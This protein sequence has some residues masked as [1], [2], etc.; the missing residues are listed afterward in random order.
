[1]SKGKGFIAI[2]VGI[3]LFSVVHAED[4][5]IPT[6][7][8]HGC[9]VLY[10]A[11]SSTGRV[12]IQLSDSRFF[13]SDDSGISWQ[14]L[15]CP[16]TQIDYISDLGTNRFH[17]VSGSKIYRSDENAANWQIFSSNI[18]YSSMRSIYYDKHAGFYYI[19]TNGGGIFRSHDEGINWQQIGQ[20]FKDDQADIISVAVNTLGYIYVS[21][22]KTYPSTY[23]CSISRSTDN[24]TSW[25]NIMETHPSNKIPLLLAPNDSIF[26]MSQDNGWV[27]SDDNGNSWNIISM[28]TYSQLYGILTDN[29][30]IGTNSDHPLM[31]SFNAGNNWSDI[32]IS[33][34]PSK[35]G[36]TFYFDPFLAASGYD[37]INGYYFIG[38][39][40]GIFR[41]ADNGASWISLN[42]NI[43]LTEIYQFASDINGYLYSSTNSGIFRTTN[44][45]NAWEQFG[46]WMPSLPTGIFIKGIENVFFA[47]TRNYTL[48]RSDDGAENWNKL[49]DS[50]SII[51]ICTDNAGVLYGLKYY[52]NPYYSIKYI[53]ST[54]RGMT[55]SEKA[56]NIDHPIKIL[57]NSKGSLFVFSEGSTSLPFGNRIYRSSDNGNS[58]NLINDGGDKYVLFDVICD[59][60]D[61]L[62]ASGSYLSDENNG[63]LWRSYDYGDHWEIIQGNE[64]GPSFN[65]VVGPGNI[66]VGSYTDTSHLPESYGFKVV[67][68]NDFGNSWENI[69][70]GLP[71]QAGKIN[72]IAFDGDGYMY[73]GG[74]FKNHEPILNLNYGTGVY[75]SKNAFPKLPELIIDKSEIDFGSVDHNNQIKAI[76]IKFIN[77]GDEDLETTITIHGANSNQFTLNAGSNHVVVPH[78]ISNSY[79]FNITFD[80]Q[81]PENGNRKEGY[82]WVDHNDPRKSSPIVI[83]LVGYSVPVE[84]SSF[85]VE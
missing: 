10:L 36:C 44:N 9:S 13:T 39:Q 45:G 18:P 34:Y 54:D 49:S 29:S 60:N 83:N 82:L 23:I 76:P 37:H 5:W 68:S 78:S 74:Y 73:V 19:G 56:A 71:D 27:R 85:A 8:P 2:F 62:F 55:W 25:T 1:M 21:Q 4:F 14:A 75:R 11:V 81:L 16:F 79:S 64:I 20:R 80:P 53:T 33:A 69:S 6:N 50:E 22:H 47:K 31:I 40:A 51:D 59:K 77:I 58:W 43:P 42:G 84:L 30:I 15:S 41:S 66:I 17:V 48:Y 24:G 63:Y 38:N 72:A 61:R 67:Q 26:A 65:L 70:A 12:M 57:R 35:L 46:K 32:S 28:G 3:F 7:G 52:Y